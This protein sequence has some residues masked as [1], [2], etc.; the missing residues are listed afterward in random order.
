M[1]QRKHLVIDLSVTVF[2]LSHMANKQDALNATFHALSDPTRRAVIQQLGHGQATVS[3]LAE[4]FEITLPT[5][6]KH[7]AVLEASGLVTS[8]KAGRIRTCSLNRRRLAIVQSWVEVQHQIWDGQ[9][10]RLAKFVETRSRKSRK[11]E[12]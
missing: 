5:F 11:N 3:E 1:T 12:P 7:I 8:R 9:P 4:P 2:I 10:E 6:L